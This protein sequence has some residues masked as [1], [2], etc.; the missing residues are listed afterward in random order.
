MNEHI[1]NNCQHVFRGQYCSN[2]GQDAHVGRLDMH[3]LLHDAWHGI[4]HTDKGVLKLVKDLALQ[5]RATYEAYFAGARKKYFSPIVFFLLSFGLLLIIN[6]WV[7]DFE[8]YRYHTN[9]EMGRYYQQAAKFKALVLLPVQV[10]LTWGFFFRR[11]NLAQVIVF[12]LYCIGFTNVIAIVF[13]LFRFAFIKHHIFIESVIVWIQY[14]IISFH[15]LA[16]FGK[17]WVNKLLT[18][19]ALFILFVA[20]VYASYFTIN[21]VGLD[22]EYP[23]LWRAIKEIFTL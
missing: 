11:Y 1:C 17:G 19:V 22:M 10:L 9:N 8:D 14:A 4:T 7:F 3:G 16:V 15:L 21:Q 6:K 12:W 23:S 20:D 2:C 18:I 13:S 5:P